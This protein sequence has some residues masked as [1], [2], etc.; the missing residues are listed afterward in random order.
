MTTRKRG[1]DPVLGEAPPFPHALGAQINVEYDGSPWPA[2]V[3]RVAVDQRS[4]TVKYL[5]DGSME[6]SVSPS[7]INQQAA[8]AAEPL[9]P[10]PEP[11]PITEPAAVE[12]EAEEEE[13]VVPEA[14]PLPSGEPVFT[15]KR[16][17]TQLNRFFS[18]LMKARLKR[19]KRKCKWCCSL[20]N[21]VPYFSAEVA[22]NGALGLKLVHGTVDMT[23]GCNLTECSSI[24]TVD[25]YLHLQ[26]EL[27]VEAHRISSME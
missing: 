4:C 8:P 2:K 11:T 3:H 6:P 18:K 17:I 14:P 9:A 16:S 7:R 10:I 20:R 21:D 26:N 5:V 1:G 23:R 13:E 15:K 24:E 19:L 22:K 12:D 25:Q 27:L